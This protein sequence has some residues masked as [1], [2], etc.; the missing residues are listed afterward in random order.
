MFTSGFHVG[1]MVKIV[2]LILQSFI[3]LDFSCK[4]YNLPFLTYKRFVQVHFWLYSRILMIRE[5]NNQIKN[6]H[7]IFT[8]ID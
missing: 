1:A 6:I 7:L 2:K 4:F 8:E 5:A 3:D